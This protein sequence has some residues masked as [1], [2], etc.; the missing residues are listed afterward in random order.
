MSCEQARAKVEQ[1]WR[2]W[3]AALEKYMS[4]LKPGGVTV[5]D[6]AEAQAIEQASQD[7]AAADHLFLSAVRE[8]LEASESHRLVRR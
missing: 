4:L 7:F 8:H 3:R 2:D 5:V 1:A 6:E